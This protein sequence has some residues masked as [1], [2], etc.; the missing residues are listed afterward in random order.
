MLRLLTR[1]FAGGG[2][3]GKD[4]R[5]I[6]FEIRL[7]SNQKTVVQHGKHNPSPANHASGGSAAASEGAWSGGWRGGAADA[8]VLLLL[9]LYYSRA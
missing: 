1:V 7:L 6:E 8:E 4:I 5:S 2:Q 9:L 3:I